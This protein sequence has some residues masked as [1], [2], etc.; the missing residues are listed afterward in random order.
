MAEEDT[1]LN[2]RIRRL[3]EYLKFGIDFFILRKR[4]PYILG[5]VTNDT[6]NLDCLHCRVAN[7]DRVNMS[8]VQIEEILKRYYRKRCRFLYLE[9][10]EPYLWHDGPYRLKDVVTLARKIGYLQVH[11]YTNGTFP[12]DAD[13][14]FTFVSIDGLA[15]T[16]EKIRGIPIGRVLANLRGFKQKYAII[17]VV[18]T[19]NYHEIRP[20]LAFVRN[21]LPRTRVMFYFHTPYYGVDNLLLSKAQKREAIETILRCK[22]EGLPVLNSATGL[23]AILS[24]NYEHPSDLWWVVDHTGEYQCC[25]AFGQKEV[26]E[27]CGYSSCAEIVLARAYSFDAIKGMLWYFR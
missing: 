23:R 14:D 15:R 10:G 8:Y 24:G 16:Y 12:L 17:F 3:W 6:C 11:I 22:K 21:E 5:L 27:A 2:G 4:R 9:G 25:R 18:N 20:F 19:V 26:C 7:I 1:A 13:P